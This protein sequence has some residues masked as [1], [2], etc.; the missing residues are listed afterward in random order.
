MATAAT[1]MFL[2]AWLFMA[3][4]LGRY[5]FG[6]PPATAA[7]RSEQE[8]HVDVDRLDM[9][10]L[11]RDMILACTHDSPPDEL[12]E[13][14]A[15]PTESPHGVTELR[16]AELVRQLLAGTLDASSYRRQMGELAQKRAPSSGMP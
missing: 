10:R 3:Y 14:P 6:A 1:A 4:H 11:R 12:G 5:L 8:P 13:L 2:L 9:D 7:Q 15:D 16:E